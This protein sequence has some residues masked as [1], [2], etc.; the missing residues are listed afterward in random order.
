MMKHI[1]EYGTLTMLLQRTNEAYDTLIA[2]PKDDPNLRQKIDAY[3]IWKGKLGW[4]V[5]DLMI[6]HKVGITLL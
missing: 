1:Q 5:A 3:D 2:A 6:E 4:Y